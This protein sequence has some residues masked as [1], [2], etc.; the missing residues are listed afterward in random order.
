MQLVCG[1]GVVS[2][3]LCSTNRAWR[4]GFKIGVSVL[5]SFDPGP[6]APFLCTVCRAS[7]LEGAV[8]APPCGRRVGHASRWHARAFVTATNDGVC[9]CYPSLVWRSIY[10]EYG[11]GGGGG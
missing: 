9:F 10:M 6:F 1:G 4:A 7:C 8:A 3:A 5:S 11:G 2:S